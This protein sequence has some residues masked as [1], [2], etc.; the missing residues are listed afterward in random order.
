MSRLRLLPY[1]EAAVL[2]E[3]GDVDEALALHADLS[4]RQPVGTV[5]VV[6]GERTVLVRFDPALTSADEVCADLARREVTGW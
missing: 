3:V 6:P 1:G 5:D 2:A 4:D